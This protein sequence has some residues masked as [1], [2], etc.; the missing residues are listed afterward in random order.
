MIAA[1]GCRPPRLRDA[2]GAD[3]R[4]RA[5]RRAQSRPHRRRARVRAGPDAFRL[6][7]RDR[8]RRGA[9]VRLRGG[10]SRPGGRRDPEREAPRAGGCAAGDRERPAASASCRASTR[11]WRP[12]RTFSRRRSTTSAGSSTRR[13]CSSTPPCSRS[14]PPAPTCASTRTRSR[15]TIAN[16]V[17]EPMDAEKIAVGRA[18]GLSELWSVQRWYEESYAVTGE[19]LWDS[20]MRNPYYEGFHASAHL[21]GYNHILDEIPNSLV[22]VSELGA[23]SAFRPRVSTPSSTSPARCA[24]STS[25]STAARS[26]CSA[27]TA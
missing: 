2:P 1:P 17:M 24:G 7:G 21:L 25:A 9:D 16:L 20:L 3:P 15:P 11:R 14:G 27:S 6:L 18:L 8:P 10:S 26:R 5:D 13:R 23:A 22:P 19:S 12:A 4:G